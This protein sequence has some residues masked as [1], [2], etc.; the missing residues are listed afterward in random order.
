[1]SDSSDLDSHQSIE[2]IATP[3]QAVIT[4]H[5]GI[6]A[7]HETIATPVERRSSSDHHDIRIDAVSA[8]SVQSIF[9]TKR[10]LTNTSPARSVNAKSVCK[11]NEIICTVIEQNGQ[12]VGIALDGSTVYYSN[13]FLNGS[14]SR[15]TA[16]MLAPCSNEIELI[17][18][19]SNLIKASDP[20]T[21]KL[22]T[23][24]ETHI[25]T[26]TEKQS[27]METNAPYLFSKT[28]QQ[29]GSRSIRLFT[30]FDT[31]DEETS[32]ESK[33]MKPLFNF[34]NKTRYLANKENKMILPNDAQHSLALFNEGVSWEVKIVTFE[35]DTNTKVDIFV[36]LATSD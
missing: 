22:V 19:R 21:I 26:D 33:V 20:K 4:T 30:S 1:L 23:D 27:F 36:R 17:E 34:Y 16:E 24:V 28:G 25:M 12:K 14:L 7:K 10:K 13:A 9:S 6:T 35:L 18:S 32:F 29:S 15:T 3:V 11:N 2:S 31:S 5:K 8:K